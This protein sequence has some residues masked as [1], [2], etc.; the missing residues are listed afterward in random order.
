VFALGI[1]LWEML[2]LERLFAGDNEVAIMEKIRACEIP[3]LEK[4]NPN[5][6]KELEAIVLK[7]LAKDVDERYAS[8]ADLYGDLTAFAQSQDI[9]LGRASASDCMRRV[10]IGDP[11]LGAGNEE[12]QLMAKNKGPSDLDVFEG[13][14]HK[15][16]PPSP[17]EDAPTPFAPSAGHAGKGGGPPMVRQ[18]TLLGMP[19]P[20][21]TSASQPPPPPRGGPS[22]AAMPHSTGLK[23]L[24]T[25][26]LPPPA[27]KVSLAPPPPPASH[28][29]A[30]HGAIA[31]A[32]RPGPAGVP[33]G[34]PG[35]RASAGAEV[36]MDWD[37]D[38]KTTVF[39][40][41]G[42][43]DLEAL[44]QPRTPRGMALPPPPARGTL[45]GPASLPGH[46][47]AP[48]PFAAPGRASIPAPP[49]SPAVSA[50]PSVG[51][52]TPPSGLRRPSAG[53]GF[54]AQS[55]HG[56]QPAQPSLPTP[57]AAAAQDLSSRADYER[58]ARQM[59]PRRRSKAVLVVFLAG[60]A[61]VAGYYFYFQRG[62]K[63]LIV[64]TGV[65]NK[66]LDKVT[67]LVDGTPQCESSPCTL[68]VPKGAHSIR[69][70]ADGYS[71]QEQ[72]RELRPGDDAVV[73]FKLERAAAG[74]GVKVSGKQ[75]GVELFVDGREI[76]PL[77]QEIKDLAPGT[78]KVV[79]KG[80]DRYAPDE[81]TIT[82]GQDEIKDLGPV[83]LKVVRGLATFELRTPGAKVTLVSGNERRR[84]TDFTQPVEIETGKNWS[85][86]ATKVGYEDFRLPITFDDR[87]DKAFQIVLTEKGRPPIA[88]APEGRV[89]VP[90]PRPVPVP[91]P[92]PPPIPGE[93]TGGGT[94]TLNFNSIPVSNV[95]MDGRPLG[96]TPKVGVSASAGSHNV[97]FIHA[98][99]GK[100][101]TSVTCKGGEIK[102]VVVRFNP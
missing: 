23:P 29:P 79:V 6:P 74:T 63:M 87:A 38:E 91:A 3:P 54:P 52:A 81:R 66:P 83:S 82:L 17:A 11:A 9:A 102:P 56:L 49:V 26:S 51:R 89:A 86:E 47:V 34:P 2:A 78:H 101:S 37:D 5:V 13:L 98:E 58:M 80:S 53:P 93:P 46:A 21:I 85:V 70:S 10:F 92:E 8:A 75:D 94:C 64:A 95:V 16:K 1:C 55:G 43:D 40:R 28:M 76:G 65:G 62:G 90:Q 60:L 41:Q 67:I 84:L 88:P 31:S 25:T 12:K 68:E 14:S 4:K 42:M 100:K 57:V 71:P 45:I 22:S 39:E 30:T 96:G 19:S 18:R 50:P 27:R 44:A 24:P 97:T 36:D 59:A 15:D 7:A 61:A 35:S 72:G 99:L 48:P 32:G 20:F 73:N 77:P 69:A 33:V